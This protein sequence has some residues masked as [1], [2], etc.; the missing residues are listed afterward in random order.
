MFELL[1][2]SPEEQQTLF[3]HLLRAF[4][5]GTPPHGGLALGLDRL[6][7]LIC[8]ES[9]IRNVIACPKNN[10][11]AGLLSNSP[12]PVDPKQLRELSIAPTKAAPK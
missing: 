5:F 6:I 4:Q 10:R 3:G 9:S 2:I 8:G 11:G 1:G 7:M 12:S